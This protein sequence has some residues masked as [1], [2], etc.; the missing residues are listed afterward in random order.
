MSPNT[1]RWRE[2]DEVA[3]VW[4][5]YH[6]TLGATWSHE[7]TNFAVWAPEATSMWICLFDEAGAETR[8]QLT[9]HTLGVWHGQIPGIPVG[10]LYG[11]RADGPWDPAHG[12]RFNPEKLLLDPYAKAISGSVTPG[13]ATL[14]YDPADPAQRSSLDSAPAMPR[15]VVVHDHFDWGG[16]TRLRTRWRDT[17]IYELHVKGYTELHNEI[18]EELRGTYAGLGTHTVTRYLQDLGVTAVELLPVH[19]HVSEPGLS[20]RGSPTTGATT[21]SASSPRTTATRRTATAASRSRVQADGQE[22]PRGRH[23]GHPGRGLQP[24]RRG[25]RGRADVLLPWSG[26]PRLLQALGRCRRHLLGR[27]RLR[28]HRGLLRPG[29]AAADPG[30]AALLGHRDAR[31]RL[32]LRPRVGAGPHRARRRHALGVPHDDQPGPGAAARQAHRRAVGRV[33][34][35]L[36][37]RLVPRRGWSGTTPTATRCATS[38]APP[39][40]GS[41]PWRP[42][43]PAP[44]TCT[45][46][47]A[48]R[49]TPR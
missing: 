40:A 36:P 47:T 20:S 13:P 32:P 1:W 38:G 14:C 45:P 31:G 34:G 25:R 33:D 49:R 46:T 17:V 44:P 18:P 8:H 37:G 41:A 48:A 42:G 15:S 3:P 21:P 28:Q 24:H 39:P 29:R 12:R 5:G 10:Q 22:L 11:L 23:R 26:R 16:D 27:H 35:R 30:L 4:P 9:E 7:A 19:Q 43:W 2:R 6:Q